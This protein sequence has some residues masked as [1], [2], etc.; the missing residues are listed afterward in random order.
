MQWTKQ[1]ENLQF[2]IVG[3][4]KAVGRDLFNIKVSSKVLTDENFPMPHGKGSQHHVTFE[5]YLEKVSSHHDIIAK[6]S[7]KL[8]GS[9]YEMMEA[10]RFCDLFPY[11]VI[12]D[13]NLMIM[14]TGYRVQLVS[15]G[16]IVPGRKMTD[17]FNITHPHIDFT[18]D[19]I[20]KF[21]TAVYNLEM[22]NGGFTLK[23]ND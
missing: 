1:V 7:L 20:L 11:H 21:I 2:F 13:S 9:D 16:D 17:C 18:W 22:N 15:K 6:D 3:L 23:G 5:V 4:L 12:Y 10:K 19:K 14:Q 8:T